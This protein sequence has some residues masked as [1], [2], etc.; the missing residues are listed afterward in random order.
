MLTAKVLAFVLAGML[1]NN[2]PASVG[3]FQQSASQIASQFYL[4][5]N[6]KLS[7]TQQQE[8]EC[9]AKVVWFEARGESKTGK[10]MVANVVRNRTEYGKPFAT[11]ICKVV[12]QP[13]QFA[14]TRNS[15]KKNTTF[16]QII[17]RHGETEKQAVLDTL[18]VSI[19]AVLFP[20]SRKTTATHFCSIGEKCKFQRVVKLG[21]VERHTFFKYIGNES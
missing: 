11:T 7:H 12:Y 17:K 20:S 9:L 18:E 3:A 16:R 21:R 8:L 15:G 6:L 1:S 13:N 4:D 5:G 14:W 10:T 2:A 19:H